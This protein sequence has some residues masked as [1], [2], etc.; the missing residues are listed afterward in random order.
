MLETV[1]HPLLHVLYM[2][3]FNR[4]VVVDTFD[5][6]LD[7]VILF[8]TIIIFEIIKYYEVLFCVVQHLETTCIMFPKISFWTGIQY[9]SHKNTKAESL[10]EIMQYSSGH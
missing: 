9:G 7:M 1:E 10:V 2:Y 6:E 4:H 8:N 3:I 5:S